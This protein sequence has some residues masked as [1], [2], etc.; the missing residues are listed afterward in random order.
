M[1]G[2]GIRPKTPSRYVLTMEGKM[3]RDE[4]TGKPDHQDTVFA[5]GI[6]MD[7]A[8]G[9]R[10]VIA[11]KDVRGEGEPYSTKEIVE[12]ADK[13]YD[14]GVKDGGDAMKETMLELAERKKPSEP[15][16]SVTREDIEKCVKEVCHAWGSMGFSLPTDVLES[17][18]KEA[19]VEVRNEQA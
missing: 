11:S 9:I 2:V 5:S 13:A 12:V 17:W 10:A 7:A 19:G 14:R 4:L 1:L 15:S 3:S 8:K 6:N 16:V 18:L